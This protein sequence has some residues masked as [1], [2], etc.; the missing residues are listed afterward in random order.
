MAQQDQKR[1][2][3][4]FEDA[5]A[6]SFELLGG[7]NYLVEQG[8]TNPEKYLVLLGKMVAKKTKTEVNVTVSIADELNRLRDADRRAIRRK[9]DRTGE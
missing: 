9:T 1:F 5:L 3:N 6:E 7:V 2:D 4:K 8:V